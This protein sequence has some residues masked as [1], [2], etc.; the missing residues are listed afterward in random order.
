MTLRP[1]LMVLFL[2]SIPGCHQPAPE[3]VG[4]RMEV[5]IDIGRYGNDV[6]FWWGTPPNDILAVIARDVRSA[7]ERA[8][9]R[10][11]SHPMNLPASG[12]VT[13][14]GTIEPVPYGEA[15]YSWGL[16]RADERRLAKKGVYLRLS[17]VQS[18]P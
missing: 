7:E 6:A 8:S 5:Q 16:T 1:S 2:C 4:R 11:A 9:G 18:R 17:E 12:T 3:A 13:L 14:R 10:P 15:R